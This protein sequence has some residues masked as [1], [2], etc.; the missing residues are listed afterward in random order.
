MQL[1]ILNAMNAAIKHDLTDIFKV[2]GLNGSAFVL[3]TWSAIID[4]L[5]VV[6]LIISI[7]YGLWKIYEGVIRH[8]W[9]KEDREDEK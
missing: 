4:P 5:K 3:V 1:E 8:R 6:S 7:S 2:I 9:R